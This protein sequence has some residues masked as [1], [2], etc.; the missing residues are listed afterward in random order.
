MRKT[1]KKNRRLTR[2]MTWNQTGKVPAAFHGKKI[3]YLI[4]KAKW[5][6]ASV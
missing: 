1:S 4:V 5:Q 3:V 6:M 2:I